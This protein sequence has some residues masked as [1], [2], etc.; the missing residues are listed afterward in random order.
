MTLTLNSRQVSNSPNCIVWNTLV[1]GRY[2]YKRLIH[3]LTSN[4]ISQG[5]IYHYFH[6]F[7]NQ[8]IAYCLG[9]HLYEP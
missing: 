3:W 9:R 4:E 2:Q 7:E 8:Y 1:G 5:E 6:W